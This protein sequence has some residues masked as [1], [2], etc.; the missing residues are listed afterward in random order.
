LGAFWGA[1]QEIMVGFGYRPGRALVWLTAMLG[2]AT[3]YFQLSGP[4]TPINPEEAPTWDPFLYSLDVP[5]PLISLGHDTVRDPTGWDK[6]IT[7][8]L[9]ITGRVLVTTVIAGLGR[10]LK[11]Q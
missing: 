2:T 3:I 6:T 1:L 4:L 11:R 5:V 9:M 10:T 7:I 8:I